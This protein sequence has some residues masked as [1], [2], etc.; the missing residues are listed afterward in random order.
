MFGYFVYIGEVLAPVLLIIGLWT[1]AAALL[2]IA[3][4]SV[5]IALAHRNELFTLGPTGGWAI[6]LQAL[7]W[8]GALAILLLGAGRLSVGG[9]HGRFN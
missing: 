9:V 3:N 8:L 1:R 5:A 6:E 4:M 7:Y 2:V